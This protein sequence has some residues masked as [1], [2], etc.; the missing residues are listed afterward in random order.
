MEGHQL[1]LNENDIRQNMTHSPS[2]DYFLSELIR[3]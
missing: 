3:V 1:H 2:L